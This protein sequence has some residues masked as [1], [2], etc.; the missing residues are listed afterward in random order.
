MLRMQ[1][2][3]ESSLLSP[4]EAPAARVLN[5]HGP[6]PAVLVCEHA[7]RFVPAALDGLGLD[8]IAA[9]SH[10][11]WDIGALDVAIEL[12]GA[13]DAPL[14][15]SR[16]SRLVY[17]C[18]RPPEREDAMPKVSEVFVVP[19]NQGL[20][21]EQ[22]AQRVRDVYQPFRS[23]LAQTLDARP[24]PPVLITIHSFTPVYNGK[25]RSVELGILHDSDDRA[26]RIMLDHAASC[27]LKVALNEPYSPVDGV[28]HTLREH[29]ISRGLPNLMI[30]IRNDLV[31]TPA[32]VNRIVGKLAPVLAATIQTVTAAGQ[33]E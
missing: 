23:A 12:M 32:G 9:R 28:T 13:L 15:Q 25:T 16:V 19:G 7:S 3:S 26:A 21:D 18:N 22:R 17:D 27:G 24:R 5:A 1:I 14:V 30:E 33:D 4:I 2:E 31:D 29:G 20:T 11:A 10:A 6:T 8:D